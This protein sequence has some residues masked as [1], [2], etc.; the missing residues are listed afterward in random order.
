MIP[1]PDPEAPAN[2]HSHPN[3]YPVF[4]AGSTVMALY[5][6]TSCFYRAE[7]TE[8]VTA[9][10][11]GRVSRAISLC[12]LCL[13]LRFTSQNMPKQQYRVRFEDDDDQIHTVPAQW[14]VE[15]PGS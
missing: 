12:H 11:E 15:W 4:G 6:D 3:S 1:L 13:T 2:S 7:V 10:R 5:P 9:P 8:V 14:V